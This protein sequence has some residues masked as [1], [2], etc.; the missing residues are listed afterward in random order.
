MKKTVLLLVVIILAGVLAYKMLSDKTKKDEEKKDQP[1]SI[2]KNSDFFNRSFSGVMDHY[3]TLE[4]ALVDWD[5]LKAD[6][7]AVDLGRAADSLPVKQI[8]GDSNL[9]LTIQ[10]LA[11]AL[12]SDVK[13]FLGETTLAGKRKSFNT[14]T[15]ELYNLVRAVKYD[16]ET[17]YHIKCPMAL[18]DSAE[19]YWLSNT[20]RVVNPY[21]GKKHPTFK[22]K[23]LGCG[24]VDDSLDFSK[25]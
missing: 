24:E 13:D 15:D 7:A 23:M 11:V 20:V 2:G 14:L 12:S 19:G 16:R 25:K 21:L 1:L 5:S 4:N 8:R 6:Q 22:D 3:Y 10:S 9:V 18:G 17:I